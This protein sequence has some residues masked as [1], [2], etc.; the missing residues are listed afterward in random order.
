MLNVQM[1]AKNPN[2]PAHIECP[3]SVRQYSANWPKVSHH[4]RANRYLRYANNMS[5]LTQEAPDFV[6]KSH[7][8]EEIRLSQ[9]R[10]Q[11]NVVLVFYPL[12]FSSVCS[13][14]LPEY[15][16]KHELFAEHNAVVLGISRDSTHTHKAWAA[17]YGIQVPLLADMLC[18]V[19]K[20]YGV[21]IPEKGHSKRA[22]FLIDTH[23]IVR[24]EYVE[25]ANGE[26]THRPDNV[27]ELLASL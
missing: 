7:Q 4:F 13:L 16:A 24:S 5:L 8:G 2:A 6:L 26:Y 3:R 12:D 23:G 18:E 21:Y 19:A 15:S 17:E 14:Q 1:L 9:F 20:A 22:T 10:G 25:T 11:K 27:L